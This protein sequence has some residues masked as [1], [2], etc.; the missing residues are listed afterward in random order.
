M[1]VRHIMTPTM[2][3]VTPWTVLR[4]AAAEMIKTGVNCL[5][6]IESRRIVGIVTAE[7]IARAAA[8]HR[9][10][11]VLTDTVRVMSTNFCTCRADDWVGDAVD[12]MLARDVGHSIVLDRAQ[13]SIG[14]LTLGSILEHRARR[15]PV[16][17]AMRRDGAQTAWA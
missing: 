12:D 7:L 9:L 11:P 17:Q 15:M 6:V 16:D 1:R 5:P 2:E 4:D 13:H 8:A 3:F 14:L 10:N